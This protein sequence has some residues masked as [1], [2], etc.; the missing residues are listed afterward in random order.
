MEA[1]K[2]CTTA[3]LCYYIF[4]ALLVFAKGI[5]LNSGDRLYYLLSA[6]A[7]VFLGGKL[8]LTRHSVKE[9][10]VIF[11]LTVM[12]LVMYRNSGR[13]AVVL[14]VLTLIGMKDIK[15]KPLF[16][17]GL[18]VWTVSFFTTLFLNLSGI[19]ESLL[20]VQE[21]SGL[22][23]IIRWGLGYNICN[24]LQ[25]TY[26]IWAI[27]VVYCLKDKYDWKWFLGLLAGNIL[28]FCYSVS[29]TGF[30]LCCLY[31]AV[32]LLYQVIKSSRRKLPDWCC[33]VLKILAYLVLPGC[34]GV[35]F[36]CPFL[37]DIKLVQIL[38]KMISYRFGISEIFLT[39][40]K[41]TLFGTRLTSMRNSW[42]LIDCAY[43]FMF[44]NYGIVAILLFVIAYQAVIHRF[45]KGGKVR[46]LFIIYVFLIYGIVEQF[47]A[48]ASLNISFLFVG[49]LLFLIADKM[50]ISAQQAQESGRAVFW[51]KSFA[52]L[53]A[54][55]KEILLENGGVISKAAAFIKDFYNGMKKNSRRIFITALLA[56]LM[57][58]IYYQT[59]GQKPDVVTIPVSATEEITAW[60]MIVKS[61]TDSREALQEK[62]SQVRQQVTEDSFLSEVCDLAEGNWTVEQLRQMVDVSYPNY[63]W[64]EE[65]YSAYRIRLLELYTEP[66]QEEYESLFQIMRDMMLAGGEDQILMQGKEI[67]YRNS[68]TEKTEDITQ[69]KSRRMER[70]GYI[71]EVERRRGNISW[72]Y[73][74]AYPV[75]LACGVYFGVRRRKQEE[76]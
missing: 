70:D 18:F 76:V 59:L 10:A 23:Y 22:G 9:Y 48:N 68:G 71:A 19:R 69:V 47:I 17:I 41:I 11:L 49:E 61:V 74:F 64:D 33:K 66:S 14:T 54:L 75:S 12:S 13:M 31:L 24:M 16:R 2:K 37:M 6:A 38:D 65:D 7:V 28:V 46:E 39:E 3:Q 40:E 8:L 63:L 36:I 26:L 35:S 45:I 55:N 20:I 53:P 62:I 5:G 72:A 21:K 32:S 34:V 1:E 4:W 58:V 73:L 43:V 42:D 52:I 56:A 51:N 27:Y 44:I 15:L 60:Q 67:I 30:A 29:V 50:Q 25:M 57:G